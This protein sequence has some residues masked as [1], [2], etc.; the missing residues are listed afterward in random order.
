MSYG[1]LVQIE[2]AKSLNKKVRYFKIID[3]REI[4]EISEEEIEFEDESHY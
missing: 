4:K 3:S 2:L 1:F